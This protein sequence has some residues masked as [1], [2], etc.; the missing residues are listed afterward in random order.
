MDESFRRPSSSARRVYLA[1]HL[2]LAPLTS[3]LPIMDYDYDTT[4]TPPHTTY[5]QGRSAPTTPR[6]L[7]HSSERPPT[8]RAARGTS[9]PASHSPP[10]TLSKSKSANHLA[11]NNRQRH[12][13]R[14]ATAGAAVRHNNHN[15]HQEPNDPDWIYRLGT[16]IS[17]EA[18]EAR[19]QSWLVSRASSSSL[20][21]NHNPL[22]SPA[23]YLYGQDETDQYTASRERAALVTS[24][25][26]SRRGSVQHGSVQHSP[27]HSRFASRTGSRSASYLSLPATPADRRGFA[28]NGNGEDYFDGGGATGANEEGGQE[29][30]EDIPGPEFVNLD[31]TLEAAFE[32][33]EDASADDEAYIRRLVKGQKGGVWSRFAK[34]FGFSLSSVSEEDDEEEEDEWDGV[35]GESEGAEDGVES[36][37]AANLKRLQA[38]TIT[39]MG[40]TR[41]PPPPED[42][43]GWRDAAWLMSVASKV[44]F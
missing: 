28:F 24:R 12:H 20:A 42:Q 19:G 17:A 27:V 16:L 23:G 11:G 9:V 44:L 37:R 14:R 26:A 10:A 34:M 32:L 4:S 22:L 39:A 6:L 18:R 30:G 13:T 21:S 43:G 8:S 36:V 2:S 15:H 41:V 38:A 7:E 1:E 31:E 33:E 25:H 5:A 3:R 35:D 40:E 29:Q